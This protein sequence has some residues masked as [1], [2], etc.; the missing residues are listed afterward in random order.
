VEDVNQLRIDGCTFWS[1][2]QKTSAELS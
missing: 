1:T 2:M